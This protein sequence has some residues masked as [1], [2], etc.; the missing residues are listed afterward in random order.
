[1]AYL[2]LV[3]LP[4]CAVPLLSWTHE[5]MANI[6]HKSGIKSY[7]AAVTHFIAY[8]LYQFC[9]LPKHK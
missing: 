7:F 3:T 4:D 1:M 5:L 6:A 9:Y 8:T 2:T